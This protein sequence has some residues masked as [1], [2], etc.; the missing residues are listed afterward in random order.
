MQIYNFQSLEQEL[1]ALEQM[2]E[3]CACVCYNADSKSELRVI[4][5][6]WWE[7]MN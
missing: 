3:L 4:I 2:S 1:A 5:R 7:L 6:E